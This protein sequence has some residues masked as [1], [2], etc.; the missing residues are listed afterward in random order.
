MLWLSSE[1]WTAVFDQALISTIQLAS[2][3]QSKII[4][5]SGINTFKLYR[6]LLVQVGSLC[7]L[8]IAKKCREKTSVLFHTK[9]G[10][11]M[12]YW[13]MWPSQDRTIIR[14]H[15]CSPEWSKSSIFKV[16]H[17]GN[18]TIVPEYT[19]A[20][21]DISNSVFLQYFHIFR[22]SKLHEHF[23]V[24]VFSY[25]WCVFNERIPE[26]GVKTLE[27]YRDLLVQVGDPCPLV[28]T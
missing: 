23:F 27:S 13:I 25:F 14:Y 17:Q 2:S 4:H 8:V 3:V 11:R 18:F 7:P 19:K 20:V 15:F 28:I 6:E 22:S 10:W 26:S 12:M 24:L 1:Y 16:L 9:N 21:H 5:E